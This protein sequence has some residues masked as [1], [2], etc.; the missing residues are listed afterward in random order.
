MIEKGVT[1]LKKY[2]WKLKLSKMQR[3]EKEDV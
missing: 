1:E 3:K 2:K